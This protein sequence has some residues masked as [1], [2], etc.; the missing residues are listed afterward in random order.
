MTKIAQ[1]DINDAVM[2]A[3]TPLLEERGYQLYS[4]KQFLSISGDVIRNVAIYPN[5]NNAYVWY[6]AFPLCEQNL[7]MGWSTTGGRIPEEHAGLTIP[8]AESLESAVGAM[9]DAVIESMQR[10]DRITDIQAFAEIL[11]AQD[12]PNRALAKA[13]CLAYL[14]DAHGAA[15][16]A[17]QYLDEGPRSLKAAASAEALVQAAEGEAIP[18]L[19]RKSTISNVRRLRLKRFLPKSDEESD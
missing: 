13:Y 14:G 11:S 12:S 2:G 8:D 1:K 9:C 3:V 18:E 17:G 7:W 5:K 15:A 19:I 6:G 4:G 10:M 16:N